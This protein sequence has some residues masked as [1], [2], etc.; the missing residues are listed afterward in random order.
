[1]ATPCVVLLVRVYITCCACIMDNCSMASAAVAAGT[2]VAL[3]AGTGEIAA[4]Q[5][6]GGG[7]GPA[8]KERA[9]CKVS[10]TELRGSHHGGLWRRH[11]V[12]MFEPLPVQG[13]SAELID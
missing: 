7:E 5:M 2:V 1:M 6:A 8:R 10:D 11:R 12:R 3:E 13:N 4:E 9:D